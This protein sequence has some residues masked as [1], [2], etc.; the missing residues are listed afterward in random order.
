MKSAIVSGCSSIVWDS[1][2]EAS[3]ARAGV[4]WLSLYRITSILNPL[5]C[6]LLGVH[7]DYLKVAGRFDYEH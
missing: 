6:L 7:A 2:W 1:Q 4:G 5:I 3:A